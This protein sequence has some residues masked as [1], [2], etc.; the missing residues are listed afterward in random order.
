MD[1]ATHNLNEVIRHLRDLIRAADENANSYVFMSC[2]KW[3]S[4]VASP[5]TTILR[6]V[7]VVGPSF[8]LPNGHAACKQG[9][10][11]HRMGGSPREREAV[12][13]R[14]HQR[15]KESSWRSF[16][17][18]RE[19]QIRLTDLR[20][21]SEIQELVVQVNFQWSVPLWSGFCRVV[22]AGFF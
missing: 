8:A 13:E 9:T 7:F 4:P 17:V 15:I 3:S 14:N 20:F 18:S 12:R 19:A 2:L 5:I 22:G 10:H 6:W 21:A 1:N 16:T 11:A